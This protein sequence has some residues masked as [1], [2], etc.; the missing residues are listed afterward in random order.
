MSGHPAESIAT[1]PTRTQSIV[2]RDRT[3][4]WDPPLGMKEPSSRQWSAVSSQREKSQ[5]ATAASE[6]MMK[7]A[8]SR[9]YH[10]IPTA[11]FHPHKSVEQQLRSPR[12]KKGCP[13]GVRYSK[14]FFRAESPEEKLE[15]VGEVSG[16]R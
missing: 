1:L 14:D 4:L 10:G 16:R 8:T 2:R 12:T 3:R 15:R 9:A 6:S 11:I 13:L 5:R 7:R